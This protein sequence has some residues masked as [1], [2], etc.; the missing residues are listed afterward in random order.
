MVL[1]VVKNDDAIRFRASTGPEG[2]ALMDMC[3]TQDIEITKIIDEI[4]TES[5]PGTRV[6]LTLCRTR[7]EE[8]TVA[9]ANYLK[10]PVS[11]TTLPFKT[12]KPD[13]KVKCETKPAKKEPVHKMRQ[14]K[15]GF[16]GS[17]GDILPIP[18]VMCCR[19]CAQIEIGRASN[20]YAAKAAEAKE[21]T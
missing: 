18:G 9:D 5:K 2:E 4:R 19:T 15:C 17:T 3:G 21:T 10:M 7:S 6:M 12:F 8:D 13:D 16:C 20:A 11:Y 1:T 14:G